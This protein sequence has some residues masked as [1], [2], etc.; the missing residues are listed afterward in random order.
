MHK[1]LLCFSNFS[2]EGSACSEKH[3]HTKSLNALGVLENDQIVDICSA[4]I[5]AFC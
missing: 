2:E 5:R 4:I 1:S 3:I